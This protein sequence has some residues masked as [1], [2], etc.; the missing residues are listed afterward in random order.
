ME[1]RIGKL[2][3]GI[4][5]ALALG[6]WVVLPARAQAPQV[7]RV[8][9]YENPPKIF[10]AENGL[11][12]G[13]YGDIL[14]FI[15]Q[16][17]NWQL[18][19][20]PGTFDEGLNRV[21]SGEIDLMV[22][23]AFSEDRAAKFDFT[24][25][26]ILSSWGVIYVPKSSMINSFADLDGKTV[27]IIKSSV[28]LGGPGGFASYT[29]AF[30]YNINFKELEEYSQVFRE[31]NE[32]RVDAALVS[33][34]SGLEAETHY[35]NIR[36]TDLIF[37]PTELRFALTKGDADTPYLIERLDFWTRE[38][39]SGYG[40]V[41]RQILEKN[42]LLGLTAQVEVIPRWVL[43][44]VLGAIAVIAI[45]LVLAVSFRRARTVALSKLAS[46]QQYL[47]KVINLAPVVL[48]VVNKEGKVILAAGNALP[49]IIPDPSQAVGMAAKDLYAGNLE[50]AEKV[51]LAFQDNEASFQA[52]IN[53]RTY[54]M[55]ASPIKTDGSINEVVLVAVDIS[56]V[57]EKEKQLE[58]NR[59]ELE[60]KK[61]ELEKTLHLMVDREL[62]MTEMKQEQQPES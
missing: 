26:T 1:R 23:V 28:Y 34:I 21:L 53:N 56:E 38:L 58:T 31:L 50:V 59:Q 35:P 30:G 13:V 46:Q 12:T 18:V 17:E 15:A 14:N 60:A 44:V 20:I 3:L 40:G 43:P 61:N 47:S 36:S 8:G 16:K 54:Q 41:Y 4:I 51:S 37:K 33:R 6:F 32:G 62:K 57:A 25:E 19:F 10:T 22:D 24:Q 48:T 49:K 2:L 11:I 29:D 5:L 27:A 39:Q 42:N 7:V 52:K 45:S 55:V 9:T